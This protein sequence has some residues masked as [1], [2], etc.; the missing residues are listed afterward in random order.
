LGKRLSDRKVGLRATDQA[1][2]LLVAQGDP[3]M[4]AR[5]IRRAVQRGIEAPLA[6]LIL[7]GNVPE[8]GEVVVDARD[9]GF[10][11]SCS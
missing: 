2:D 7:E 6:R 9:G 3:E 8:G 5:P 11:L 1:L 4:G 10:V